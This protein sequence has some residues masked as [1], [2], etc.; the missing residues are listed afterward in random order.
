MRST[1]GYCFNFGS[2]IFSWSS[3]KQEVIAQSPAEAEYV[4][5]IAVVNQTIWIRKL[6]VDLQ[7]EQKES[8][9]I[10]VD[11]QAAISIAKNPVFHGKTKHFKLKLYFL[12]EVQREGEIQLIYCKTENQNVDI[13]TKRLPQAKYEFFRQRLGVCSFR[14][15]EEC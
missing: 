3:K 12:R 4:A 7:M 15:K 11:N 13:L 5:A 14:A 1:S 2:A 10:L 6:V 8:T 9:Q